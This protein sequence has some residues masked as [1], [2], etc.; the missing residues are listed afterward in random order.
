MKNNFKKMK[1]NFFLKKTCFFEKQKFPIK[2]ENLKKQK[3]EKSLWKTC[4]KL[5]NIFNP[6]YKR[7]GSDGFYLHDICPSPCWSTF[8]FWIFPSRHF[9]CLQSML[10]MSIKCVEWRGDR[11]M[12]CWFYGVDWS[13]KKI[14]RDQLFQNWPWQSCLGSHL[15]QK[16]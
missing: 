4:K 2:I 6:S 1:N 8:Q 9:W 12:R 7:I 13:W 5:F 14:F 15:H 11:W 16:E 10:H 3:R